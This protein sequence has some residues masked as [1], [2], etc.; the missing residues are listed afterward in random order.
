MRIKYHKLCWEEKR[1]R[2]HHKLNK[3]LCANHL[4]ACRPTWKKEMKRGTHRRILE[5]KTRSRCLMDCSSLKVRLLKEEVES[6]DTLACSTTLSTSSSTF[7]LP[8]TNK[9]EVAL[10][11]PNSKDDPSVQVGTSL[12]TSA[13]GFP[14]LV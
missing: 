4:R 6:Y 8:K 9:N 11:L 13:C 10:L 2:R 1:R 3:W 14:F 7:I 5:S 12:Q